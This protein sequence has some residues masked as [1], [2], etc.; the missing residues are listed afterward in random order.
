VARTEKDGFLNIFGLKIYYRSFGEE[1]RKGT[2]VCLHGGPGSEHTYLLPLADLAKSGYRVVLYDQMGCGK[3]ENP[4]DKTALN[5]E[6]HVEELER[7]RNGLNLGKIH[8]MGSSWGGMLALSYALKY[9]ENLRSIITTGGLASTPLYLKEVQGRRKK[10]PRDVYQTML[11]YEKEGDYINPNYYDAV[12][13]FYR[14]YLCR[15]P[16]WPPEVQ[17]SIQHMSMAVYGTMWGPN[18][19]TCL[20]SL[21]YWDITDQLH[22]I[23]VPTLIT[24]AKYDE[25]SPN[26]AMSMHR[27]IKGSKLAT[28]QKSAHLPMW[29]EREKY[30]KVVRTFL[31]GLS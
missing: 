20:G 3:S 26:V 16:V 8:L 14:Q 5:V 2:L 15:L 12:M 21:R 22:K 9:Q 29:D 13:Y 10:L 28:F 27:E 1:G 19:F 6:R 18:E 17:Y 11:K 24:T 23:S 30:L 4:R 25:V 7:V 31:D